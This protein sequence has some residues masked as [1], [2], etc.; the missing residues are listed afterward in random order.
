MHSSFQEQI[1]LIRLLKPERVVPCVL[2]VGTKKISDLT[3]YF[4]GYLRKPIFT[5]TPTTE[6]E[7]EQDYESQEV[8]VV[9]VSEEIKKRKLELLEASLFGGLVGSAD[10]ESLEVESSQEGGIQFKPNEAMSS[11]SSLE[12]KESI[13]LVSSLEVM[14]SIDLVDSS[15]DERTI[16]KEDCSVKTIQTASATFSLTESIQLVDDDDPPSKRLKFGSP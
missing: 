16:E 15:D 7:S 14:E 3:P 10:E 2:P 6:L 8:N 5:P 13:D 1:D 12:I 11:Y 4:E 9:S